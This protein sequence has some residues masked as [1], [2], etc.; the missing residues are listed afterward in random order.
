MYYWDYTVQT[1][2]RVLKNSHKLK[3]K[4]KK[5]KMYNY[6]KWQNMEHTLE[7]HI[8]FKFSLLLESVSVL[9]PPFAN[10]NPHVPPFDSE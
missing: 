1:V 8:K 7:E 6:V 3:Q 4:N 10:A 5:Q 9:L 2:V